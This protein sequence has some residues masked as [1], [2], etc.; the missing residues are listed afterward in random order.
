MRMGKKSEMSSNEG[1]QREP[2][3]ERDRQFQEEHREAIESYNRF[4]AKYGIWSEKY[5]SW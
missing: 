5:R 3:A 1:G 2:Q 4:I